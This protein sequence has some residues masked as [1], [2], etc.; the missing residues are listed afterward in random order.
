MRSPETSSFHSPAANKYS[1]LTLPSMIS[2]LK[3]RE[4]LY[5]FADKAANALHEGPDQFAGLPVFV[6]GHQSIEPPRTITFIGEEQFNAI[7]IGVEEYLGTG[8]G[9][10]T[11][12]PQHA[13]SESVVHV[14]VVCHQIS[15]SRKRFS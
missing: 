6:N 2:I 8:P 11:C 12:Q 14:N 9:Y 5:D 15:F 1:S 7:A 3:A 10:R 4:S 13:L